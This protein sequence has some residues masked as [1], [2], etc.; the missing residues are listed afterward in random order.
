M[1]GVFSDIR[2]ML[3]STKEVLATGLKNCWYRETVGACMQRSIRMRVHFS[4]HT[5]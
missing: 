5:I 4:F 3:E 1:Q 2:E